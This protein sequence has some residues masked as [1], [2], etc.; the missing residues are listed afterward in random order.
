[1]TSRIRRCARISYIRAEPPFLARQDRRQRRSQGGPAP[2]QQKVR[3]DPREIRYVPHWS[4]E[5]FRCGPAGAEPR[6]STSP[7]LEAGFSWARASAPHACSASTASKKRPLGAMVS[8]G[9]QLRASRCAKREVR[10]TSR[11]RAASQGRRGG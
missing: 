5:M 8:K 3:G 9:S 1:M 7:A 6:W 2:I 10:I 11:S 4:S